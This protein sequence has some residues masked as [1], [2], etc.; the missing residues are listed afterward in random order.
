MLLVS[1]TGDWTRNVPKEEYPAIKRIYDLYGKGDQVEVVQIHEVHNFNQ[2]SRE[3]VYRFFAKHHPGLSDPKELAEHD[4]DVPMLQEMMV[5]S[6]RTLPSGALDLKGLFGE[7][8]RM[9]Q[10]STPEDLAFLRERLR[11]TLAVEIPREVMASENGQS[12]VLARPSKKDR[13]PGIWISGQGTTAIVIDGRGSS[14]ALNEDVVKRLQSEGRPILLLDVFQTGAAKS[15]RNR[16]DKAVGSDDEEDRANAAAGDP[17]F[18]TFNVTDDAARV[19]D[20]VTAIV[21]ASQKNRKVDLYASGEAACG[22]L[23]QLR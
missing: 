19:Q 21:Y 6:N 16:S 13:V 2:L 14:S 22:L 18:L 20:I 12:I 15:E 4:V 8:R 3:A 11:Q 10:E 1:A 23:L 7:W 17:K 5:L 9:A